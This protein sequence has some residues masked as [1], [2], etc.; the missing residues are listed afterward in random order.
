MGHLFNHIWPVTEDRVDDIYV[1][2][3]GQNVFGVP[4]RAGRR[5]GR[6][7]HRIPGQSGQIDLPNI[8]RRVDG[9]AGWE[10][11]RGMDQRENGGD[12]EDD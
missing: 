2:S 4:E 3:P 6:A 8:R 1:G 5:P 7:D 9:L 10:T 11:A 12:D